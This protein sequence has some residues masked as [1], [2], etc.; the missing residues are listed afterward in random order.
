MLAPRP[1]VFPSLPGKAFI[2]NSLCRNISQHLYI[3]AG[4]EV[5]HIIF[6]CLALL[7]PYSLPMLEPSSEV[8][9]QVLSVFL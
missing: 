1:P 5:E 6:G 4:S 9:Q 2:I 3:L 7:A 8:S